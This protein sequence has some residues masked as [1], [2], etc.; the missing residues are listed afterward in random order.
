MDGT[1]ELLHQIFGT[2]ERRDIAIW[3]MA[4]RAVLVYTAIVLILRIGKKRSLG[5]ATAFDFF[6][7]VMMGSIASRAVTGDAPI[8]GALA[9]CLSMIALHW[10]FSRATVRWHGLGGIIKGHPTLLVKD[11]KINEKGM[12]AAHLSTH[13]L[14]A[15]LRLHNVSSL[16]QV[17]EARL[18][19]SGSISVLTKKTR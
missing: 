6:L 15:E 9:A 11:G 14:D 3:Q 7:G 8:P 17:S 16:D 4:L 19:R 13:D 18:E 1:D 12:R 5:N 2:P 10:L